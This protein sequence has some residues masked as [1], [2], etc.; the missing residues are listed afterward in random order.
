M[1]KN[2]RERESEREREREREREGGRDIYIYIYIYI[3]FYDIS[4]GCPHNRY[5]DYTSLNLTTESFLSHSLFSPPVMKHHQSPSCQHV[6][7]HLPWCSFSHL[8]T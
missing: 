7:G 3:P 2:E 5:K 4:E 8:F 1:S 6:T